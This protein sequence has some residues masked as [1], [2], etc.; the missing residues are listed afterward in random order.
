MKLTSLIS[1]V[2]TT[3]FLGAN[4]V[5][6]NSDF[7]CVNPE[8]DLTTVNSKAKQGQLFGKGKS[9]MQDIEYI[10]SKTCL[11]CCIQNPSACA[12]LG[13]YCIPCSQIMAWNL[14]KNE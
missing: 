6:R 1:V 14:Q 2:A 5:P 11:Q 8:S 12:P 3:L 10:L 7:K 9:G 4:A 13:Q